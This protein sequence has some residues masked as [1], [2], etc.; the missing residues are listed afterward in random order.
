MSY[1]GPS[2]RNKSV[3]VVSIDVYISCW[4]KLQY[5]IFCYSRFGKY[6]EINFD[7]KF[8]IKGCNIT[9]YLLEKTRVVRVTQNERNYHV[10]YMLVAGASV[11]QRKEFYLKNIDQFA[12]LT[13]CDV[14]FFTNSNEWV[15]TVISYQNLEDGEVCKKPLHPVNLSFVSTLVRDVVLKL[16]SLVNII[17]Q[18]T[19]VS[20]WF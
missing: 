18:L 6:M 8:H 1:L 3:V 7:K 13:Q 10:F 11:E 2:P 9:S 12:Y 17:L 5:S 19:I 16:T 4:T 14:F 15:C 20:M